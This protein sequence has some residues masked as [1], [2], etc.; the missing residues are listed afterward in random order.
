MPII[1]AQTIID[2]DISEIK[3]VS[4]V[5]S[6]TELLCHLGLEKNI[7]GCTKFCEHP[8]GLKSTAKIIGGTKNPRIDDILALGPN[9]V[10]ANKEENR[11][12]DVLALSATLN[13]HVSDI[14]SVSDFS[15]FV[16]ELGQ[17]LSFLQRTS[18]FIQQLQQLLS[19]LKASPSKRVI[20][21]IWKKPFMAAGKGTYI[22][23]VLTECGYTNLVNTVRYPELSLSEITALNPDCIFL[24]SEPYPFGKQDIQEMKS[25]TTSDVKLVDGELFSWYSNR[26]FHIESHLKAL[27]QQ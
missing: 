10:F 11:K 15:E 19:N 8:I 9:I 12:E 25:D 17:M 5:P 4:L 16:T 3:I 6:I 2:T 22:D 13:V 27:H 18:V 14:N 26:I 20:Y 7:N 21:L 1:G 23:S 24:S